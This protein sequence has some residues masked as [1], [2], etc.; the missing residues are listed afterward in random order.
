MWYRTVVTLRVDRKERERERE[1]ERDPD[2]SGIQPPKAHPPLTY[3]L[4]LGPT[5]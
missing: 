2:P 1:R 5:S 3:F 4:Q